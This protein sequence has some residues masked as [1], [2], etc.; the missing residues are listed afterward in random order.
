QF[1]NE[2][3]KLL[4]CVSALAALASAQEFKLGSA[5][6]D[7]GLTSVTGEPVKYSALKGDT[8]VVIFVSTACPIS[9]AYNDRMKAVYNHYAGKGVRFVFVNA[10]STETGAEV[11]AHAKA[12]GF[13]FEV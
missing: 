7:F 12:H 10:N 6:G 9:N 13:P 11:A 8:T 2:M 5:V 3:K 4:L 1:E